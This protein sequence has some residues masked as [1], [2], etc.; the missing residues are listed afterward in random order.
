MSA[1]SG[2]FLIFFF[3]R[4]F[5]PG[6]EAFPLQPKVPP[7]A[8]HPRMAPS[9]VHSPSPLPSDSESE[10]MPPSLCRPLEVGQHGTLRGAGP[11]FAGPAEPFSGK[12]VSAIH[13]QAPCHS[14]PSSLAAVQV[15]QDGPWGVGQSRFRPQQTTNEADFLA[16]C[17]F[18]CFFLG[19][20]FWG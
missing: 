17:V 16:A 6:P 14:Q 5:S 11:R 10:P 13:S 8:H 18:G 7:P 19:D 3:F 9:V 20:L 1:S 15:S 12:Q 4:V 2:E